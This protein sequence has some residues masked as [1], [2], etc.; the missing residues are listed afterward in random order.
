MNGV[1]K[2]GI[3]GLFLRFFGALLNFLLSIYIARYLIKEEYGN[4]QFL[5]TLITGLSIFSRVGMD[6]YLM[7]K[8]PGEENGRKKFYALKNS[9]FL[10]FIT[11]LTISVLCL[12]FYYIYLHMMNK[13]IKNAVI[14]FLSLVPFSL[15]L[16]ISSIEKA[17]ENVNTYLFINNILPPSFLFLVLFVIQ[18]NK[19]KLNNVFQSYLL[20]SFLVMLISF[21]LMS[22]NDI[23]YKMPIAVKK[24]H[25]FLFLKKGAKYIPH[26]LLTYI[27]LWVDFFIVSIFLGGEYAADYSVA[28]RFTLIILLAMSVYDGMVAPIIIKDFKIN[29]YS[30][31][32]KRKIFNT[33]LFIS[34]FVII[35]IVLTRYIVFLYGDEYES[36]LTVAHILIIAYAVKGMASLPGYVLIAMNEVSKIN[37]ILLLSLFLN[38][39]ASYNLMH[40]YSIAGVAIG[41]LMSSTVVVLLSYYLMFRKLRSKKVA[42]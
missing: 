40:Y 37:R 33:V 9:I 23:K 38:I 7:S 36:S 35:T 31:K 22:R 18:Y 41:T 24:Y 13:E 10:V 2:K 42:L 28:S 14:I 26:S 3:V 21:L 15:Y 8:L 11:S 30:I 39:I 19:D 17:K 16:L 12:I 25:I 27:L 29:E 20:S 4:Y 34:F 32:L 1:F 6:T 5:I